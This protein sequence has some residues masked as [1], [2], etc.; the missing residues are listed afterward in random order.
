MFIIFSFNILYNNVPEQ[1][2]LLCHCH[3][4]FEMAPFFPNKLNEF[5]SIQIKAPVK[6]A[7][8]ARLYLEFTKSFSFYFLFK[9]ENSWIY[10]FQIILFSLL[11]KNQTNFD[12]IFLVN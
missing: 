10:Y 8:E 4:R 9:M 6:I 3:V 7:N 5:A 12:L 2:I 11:V 1:T